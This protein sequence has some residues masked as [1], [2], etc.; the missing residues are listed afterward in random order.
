MA[1]SAT[2]ESILDNPVPNGSKFATVRFADGA[3]EFRQ[4]MKL[5]ASLAASDVPT[6]L[7][8]ECARLDAADRTAVDLQSIIGSEITAAAPLPGYVKMWQARAVL[9]RHG[10][11]PAVDTAIAASGSAAW[12]AAWEYAPDISRESPLVAAM[13]QALGL[14]DAEVDA[15][16]AEA[17]TLTA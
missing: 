17:A 1:W 11:L 12:Q 10:H 9:A 2:V 14:S 6:F 16:F 8:A 7:A 15:L 3:R 13:A 4:Q 5:G